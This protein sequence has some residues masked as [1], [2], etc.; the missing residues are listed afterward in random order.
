MDVFIFGGQIGK[1]LLVRAV[2]CAPNCKNH[3][4]GRDVNNVEFT[5][6]RCTAGG[7]SPCDETK[8]VF[9]HTENNVPYCSFGG[10]DQCDYLNIADRN[11]KW[12]GTNTVIENGEYRVRVVA[13][14]K[15]ANWQGSVQIKIQR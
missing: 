2:A 4:D 5:F 15:N 8:K 12:P 7:S 6:S 10:A 14:G 3:P 13:K 1:S 11:A 9:A